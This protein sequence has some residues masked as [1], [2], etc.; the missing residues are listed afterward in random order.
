MTNFIDSLKKYYNL[1]EAN[2]SLEE[3]S[4]ELNAKGKDSGGNQPKDQ[5]GNQGADAAMPPTQED[6]NKLEQ[7]GDQVQNQLKVNNDTIKNTITE[8]VGIIG[9]IFATNPNLS[10]TVPEAFKNL[11]AKL[12]DASNQTDAQKY[13]DSLNKMFSTDNPDDDVNFFRNK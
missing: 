8:L 1:I 2:D 5:D 12:K 13:I 4:K 10:N 3:L 6:S 7:E 9:Q 11:M